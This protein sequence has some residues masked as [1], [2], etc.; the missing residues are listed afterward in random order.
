WKSIW[1]KKRTGSP[2][3]LKTPPS[4]NALQL[5]CD[6]VYGPASIAGIRAPFYSRPSRD[7]FLSIRSRFSKDCLPTDFIRRAPFNAVGHHS[8]SAN[9][10][11]RKAHGVCL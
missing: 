4:A 1:K 6:K 9:C 7:R 10:F 3:K 11:G 5:S 8:T 2:Q